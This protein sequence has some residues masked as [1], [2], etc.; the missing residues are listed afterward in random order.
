[1]I[2]R[3]FFLS[4]FSTIDRESIFLSSLLSRHYI[5]DLEEDD[6]LNLL[7]VFKY[8]RK[9]ETE[10]EIP[11]VFPHKNTLREEQTK[12]EEERFIYT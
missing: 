10:R 1:M 12:R 9:D 2:W 5:P 8:N 7:D 4:L 11:C 6:V 3:S